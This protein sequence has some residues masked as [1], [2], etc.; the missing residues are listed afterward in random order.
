MLLEQVIPSAALQ[1]LVAGARTGTGGAVSSATRSC[2][3][4][5]LAERARA[6][7]AA[8]GWRRA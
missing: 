5:P 1:Q 3:A 2:V 4:A 8:A 7:L 6:E